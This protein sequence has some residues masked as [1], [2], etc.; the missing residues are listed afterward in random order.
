V[1]AVVDIYFVSHGKHCHISSRGLPES[2]I[3]IVYSLAIGIVHGCKP[4]NG[5]DVGEKITKQHPKQVCNQ[6]LFRSKHTLAV[7][8][9]SFVYST[10]ILR[11]MGAEE[12]ATKIGVGYTRCIISGVAA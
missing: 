5:S 2:V 8:I 9:L 1:F 12:A 11:L 7:S 3:N 4:L 10:T 6:Y